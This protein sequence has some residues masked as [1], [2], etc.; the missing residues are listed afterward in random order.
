MIGHTFYLYF[1]I[2]KRMAL[3][4]GGFAAECGPKGLDYA[5]LIQKRACEHWLEH[6]H[7][8]RH[9]LRKDKYKVLL[10]DAGMI[11]DGW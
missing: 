5:L 6:G 8:G 1:S 2:S 10:G 11:I 7:R 9:P 3:R 4:V